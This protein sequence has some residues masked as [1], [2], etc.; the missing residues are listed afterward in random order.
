MIWYCQ[1]LVCFDLGCEKECTLA[2]SLLLWYRFF[3]RLTLWFPSWAY[4]FRL[5]LR[6]NWSQPEKSKEWTK[7]WDV[8]NC[9]RS[10]QKCGVEETETFK[11]FGTKKI[12]TKQKCESKIGFWKVKATVKTFF[13]TITVNVAKIPRTNPLR[14]KR[15]IARKTPEKLTISQYYIYFNV[16]AIIVISLVKALFV[17]NSRHTKHLLLILSTLSLSISFCCSLSIPLVLVSTRI[18]LLSQCNN[19]NKNELK[20]NKRLGI[21]FH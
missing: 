18:K 11:L 15:R 1:F 14:V 10:N 5:R 9:F 12:L 3:P 19:R 4:I 6:M 2:L 13:S 7:K 17:T 21:K 16:K 8:E 20:H